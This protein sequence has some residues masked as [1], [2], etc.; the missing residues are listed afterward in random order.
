MRRWQKVL[1]GRGRRRDVIVPVLSEADIKIE[2]WIQQLC[3]KD[4]NKHPGFT[5]CWSLD[6]EVYSETDP[7][8]TPISLIILLWAILVCLVV[9]LMPTYHIALELFQCALLIL[10]WSDFNDWLECI[11]PSLTMERSWLLSR[12]LI[13]EIL[14]RVLVDNFLSPVLD[15]NRIRILKNFDISTR[16]C[17]FKMLR[18]P[19]KNKLVCLS[20][21]WRP[22]F[23]SWKMS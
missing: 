16:E 21:C 17:D 1:L 10:G 12:I 13:I 9:N 11:R 18:V 15:S 23:M 14:S 2:I 4:Q 8:P 7:S 6:E 3:D 22:L 5:K 19:S 20:R